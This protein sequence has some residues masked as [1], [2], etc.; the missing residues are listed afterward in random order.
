MAG[1]TLSRHQR[2]HNV[3]SSMVNELREMAAGYR[4]MLREGIDVRETPTS[5]KVG[6]LPAMKATGEEV[7]A[8][9]GDNLKAVEQVIA[10]ILEG[11]SNKIVRRK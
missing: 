3:A 5:D 9:L 6:T 7:R 10:F 1:L 8:A 2:I 4:K 11:K